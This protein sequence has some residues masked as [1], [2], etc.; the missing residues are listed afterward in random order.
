MPF[1]SKSGPVLLLPFLQVS[2]HCG[3]QLKLASYLCQYHLKNSSFPFVC[4]FTVHPLLILSWLVSFL[5]SLCRHLQSSPPAISGNVKLAELH[6]F[7]TSILCSL[8]V[9]HIHGLGSCLLFWSLFF[10]NI[11]CVPCSSCL[12]VLPVYLAGLLSLEA[13]PRPLFWS[14]SSW[15][16]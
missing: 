8:L 13:P 3:F 2:V 10:K 16:N 7:R 14:V 1:T 15:S 9:P 4:I 11:C 6:F 5:S 12:F